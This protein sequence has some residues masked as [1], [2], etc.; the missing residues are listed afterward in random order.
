MGND[1]KNLYIASRMHVCLA[2]LG[3]RLTLQYGMHT[4]LAPARVTATRVGRH[5]FLNND[6]GGNCRI[7]AIC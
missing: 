6:E 1:I 2:P 7:V 3:Y 4:N 5:R